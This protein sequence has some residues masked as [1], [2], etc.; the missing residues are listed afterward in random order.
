MCLDLQKIELGKDINPMLKFKTITEKDTN[1]VS[2][3]SVDAHKTRK[4]WNSL[5]ST[6]TK[7]CW[8]SLSWGKS[9]MKVFGQKNIM[10]KQF[11][12]VLII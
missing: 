3:I 12:Q 5:D 1:I 6:A 8:K 4:N 9:Y 7:A 2:Q 11:N 10:N